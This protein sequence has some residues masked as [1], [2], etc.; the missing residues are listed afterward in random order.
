ML[1]GGQIFSPNLHGAFNPFLEQNI[2]TGPDGKFSSDREI[3]ASAALG[4]AIIPGMLSVGAE[5]KG[6]A[7]Q[8]DEKDYKGVLKVGPS[9]WLN[10]F[11]SHFRITYAGLIGVTKRSD[12]FNPFLVLG[13]AP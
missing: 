12:T 3:G 2:D 11:N 8:Q 7:D 9:V 6:A 13:Y 1:I 5:I 10:L 4:Y